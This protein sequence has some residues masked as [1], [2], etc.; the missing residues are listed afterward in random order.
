MRNFVKLASIALALAPGIAVAAEPPCLTPAEFSALSSYALPSVITGAAQR[1]AASL[2]SDAYLRVSGSELASRYARTKDSA[3]PGAKAAF[4]KAGLASNPDAAELIKL[5]P[6]ETLQRFVDTAILSLVGQRLPIERCTAVDSI[7][8][9]LSP[10]PPQNAA[11]LIGLAA[12]LGSKTGNARI[13][14]FSICPA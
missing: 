9:L 10:L 14:A 8:R 7:V 5:M 11:E 4:L 1:C 3:W 2:P 13:G 6:D 12:G